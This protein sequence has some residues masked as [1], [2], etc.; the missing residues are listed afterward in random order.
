MHIVKQSDE[1]SD[2]QYVKQPHE[3]STPCTV[4]KPENVEQPHEAT[5][6]TIFERENVKESEEQS[7]EQPP[8]ASTPC[9]IS[10]PE[11]VESGLDSCI[12][13]ETSNGVQEEATS[14]A[15]Q[16]EES[17]IKS[18]NVVQNSVVIQYD[19][20]PLEMRPV[21]STVW[22]SKDAGDE[23][24]NALKKAKSVLNKLS[25]EKF[26]KLSVQFVDVAVHSTAVLKEC[27]RLIVEKARMECHFSTMY[28]ELC[29][30]ISTTEMPSLKKGED[31]SKVFRQILLRHCQTIF[32]AEATKEAVSEI[33]KASV[34]NKRGILGHIRF[35]GELYKQNMLSSRIMH[36][37][38]IRLFG[39]TDHVDEENLE[40]LCKLLTTIGSKL[41]KNNTKELVENLKEYYNFI[42]ILSTTS[43]LST[44]LRF[45]LLDLLELRA[46]R[47]VARR[48]KEVAT[49][50]AEVHKQADQEQQK[51][52]NGGA[53]KMRRKNNNVAPR[54]HYESNQSADGWETVTRRPRFVKSRSSGYG[55]TAD[56]RTATPP[57]GR[58]GKY[59]FAPLMRSK[60]SSFS[61]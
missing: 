49:T 41:E 51:K 16:D 57:P 34:E 5:P 38:I 21:K 46:N 60:S 27:I 8:E 52:N 33:E 14:A 48:E 29:Q 18:E 39:D 13:G 10:K 24:A 15:F 58:A 12:N 47:W 44:R 31:T 37:C 25:I 4:S 7:V 19:P 40:C 20:F 56:Q 55:S 32:E 30:K 59:H 53:G 2:E 54:S 61:Q 50:L 6:C 11:N 35:I 9:T 43:T 45:M 28:A 3:T 17:T 36:S 22:K 42:E 1:Q 26:D 23:D